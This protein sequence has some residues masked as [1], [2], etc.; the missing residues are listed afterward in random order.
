MAFWGDMEDKK[1][2]EKELTQSSRRPEHKG[3]REKG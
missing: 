3:H 2:K 1:R